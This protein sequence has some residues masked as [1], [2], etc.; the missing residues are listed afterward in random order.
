MLTSN[1]CLHTSS[2]SLVTVYDAPDTANLGGY[3][4]QTAEC[5]CWKLL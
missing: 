3:L 4:S 5:A 2:W 1:A